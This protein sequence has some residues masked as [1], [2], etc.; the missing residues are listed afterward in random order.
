MAKIWIKVDLVAGDNQIYVY[1]GNENAPDYSNGDEVFEFFDDF[2]GNELD[3]NKWMNT[4]ITTVTVDNGVLKIAGKSPNEGGKPAVISNVTFSNYVVETLVAHDTDDSLGAINFWLIDSYHYVTI[5]HETRGG[6]CDEDIRERVSESYYVIADY[7]MEWNV[8]EWIKYIIKVYD[9]KFT[10]IRGI[11]NIPE[12]T[13]PNG[14]QTIDRKIGFSGDALSGNFLVDY[15][16]VR[17]YTEQEPTVTYGAEETGS[18]EKGGFIYTKRKKVT[19]NSTQN[20]T[21]Y[22][23]ALDYSQFNT[24]RLYIEYANWLSG[25]NYRRLITIDNSAN[26]ENLTDYQ[27]LVTLDNTNFDFTKANSDGSDIRFTD[28]DGVTIL[29]HW[30]EEWDNINQI[31]KIWVKVPSI[32]SGSTTN[33]YMY[34]GNN[35][36]I[37]A[38][39]GDEVFEFF[40]DFDGNELDTNK[41]AIKGSPDYSVS[42]SKLRI[43]SAESWNIIYSKY[44]L[45]PNYIIETEYDNSEGDHD[46]RIGINLDTSNT[47]YV[48][49]LLPW[50]GGKIHIDKILGGHFAGNYR[51]ISS[52]PYGT[53]QKVCI[54]VTDNIIKLITINDSIILSDFTVDRF[55][56]SFA[57]TKDSEDN[58]YFKYIF[59]RK[60]TEQEP[61]VTVGKEESL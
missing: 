36:A 10:I 7:R 24:S 35:A 40:D 41:W 14:L 15:V 5:Q 19:I 47:D 38:S 61:T 37:D 34:Y 9:N 33:I 4:G 31:A 17:K 53:N 50:E 52:Y 32:L 25:F 26:S 22:Q 42:D 20:L 1:Y 13:E 6:G 43:G 3:T 23:V 2:D 54:K 28:S 18:W 29:N 49:C 45:P 57:L 30:I 51:I 11:Q 16:F 27:I 55:G 59:V 12:I 21:D 48:Q 60:Y 44:N 46:T 39:N 56:N 58:V 8:N